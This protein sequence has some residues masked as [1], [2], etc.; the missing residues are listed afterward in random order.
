MKLLVRLGSYL[1][2]GLSAFGAEPSL[3]WESDGFIGPESVVRDQAR[4]Q[5]LVSNMGTYGKAPT[6]GDGFISRVSTEGKMLEAQW[7]KG[8]EDPKGLSIVGDRLYV[9]DVDALVEIDLVKGTILARYAPQDGRG[10]FNDCTADPAGNVYVCSGRLMTVFRLH[11]GVFAPWVK[12]DPKQTGGLNGLLAEKDRLLLGGW[13]S[14]DENGTEQLGHIS[15]V[16]FQTLK[17]ARLGTK[18]VCHIDGLEPDGHGGYTA[19]DWVT[20]DVLH[21][22]AEGESTRLMQLPQGSADH[23]YLRDVGVLVI[24]LMKDNVLRAYRWTPDGN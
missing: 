11:N 14:K 4:N 15:T 12:L 9:G 3:L 1:L 22:S 2:V 23:T 18:P 16:D 24:P 5:L 17:V 21:L 19:T 13:S 20:G 8:L 6:A 10:D 7:V